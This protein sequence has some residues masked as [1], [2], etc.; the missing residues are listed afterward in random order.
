MPQEQ[1]FLASRAESQPQEPM[2]VVLPQL[3][4]AVL[5]V[6]QAQPSPLFLQVVLAVQGQEVRA[7]LQ[8]P[9]EERVLQ[10][11][12]QKLQVSREPQGVLP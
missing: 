12:L 3:Q 7:S 5:G 11:R 8:E 10:G 1:V 6:A 2:R 4:V 9:Q